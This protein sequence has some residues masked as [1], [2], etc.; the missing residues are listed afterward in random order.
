MTL[1]R[2]RISFSYKENVIII[3]DESKKIFFSLNC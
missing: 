3:K 1:Y 2:K